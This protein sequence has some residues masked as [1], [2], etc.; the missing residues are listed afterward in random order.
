LFCFRETKIN[1]KYEK[2]NK[3]YWIFY[4]WVGT[5]D[6]YNMDYRSPMERTK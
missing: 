2:D 4:D 6:G 3:H 1:K 5:D